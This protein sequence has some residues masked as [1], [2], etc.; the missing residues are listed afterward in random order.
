[1]IHLQNQQLKKMTKC[2]GCLLHRKKKEAEVKIEES[3][4]SVSKSGKRNVKPVD[5]DPH[6]EKLL[7]VEAPLL[8]TTKYLNMLQIYWML[9]MFFR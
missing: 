4:V 6:G 1:M 5:P 7:L 8:E 3:S 2:R 9:P